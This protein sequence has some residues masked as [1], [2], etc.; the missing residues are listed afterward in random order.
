MIFKELYNIFEEWLDCGL[1]WRKTVLQNTIGNFYR[2]ILSIFGIIPNKM[3][4]KCLLWHSGGSFLQRDPN[5]LSSIDFQDFWQKKF[6][7]EF[8]AA[9]SRILLPCLESWAIGK[10]NRY[11]FKVWLIDYDTS[12]KIRLHLF[13]MHQLL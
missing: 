12:S 10:F 4:A 8:S 11:I 7:H 2:I 5:H 9:F 3:P 13:K 6:L 1:L